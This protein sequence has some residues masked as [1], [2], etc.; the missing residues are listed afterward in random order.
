MLPVGGW[1]YMKQSEGVPNLR[2]LSLVA[3]EILGI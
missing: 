3:G 1:E 2:W